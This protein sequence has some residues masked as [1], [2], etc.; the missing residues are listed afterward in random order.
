MKALL[1]LKKDSKKDF[2]EKKE[3]ALS[4]TRSNGGSAS[5]G[6]A[7]GGQAVSL[8][9][10]HSSINK[11]LD[12]QVAGKGGSVGGASF[13]GPMPGAAE[14][15]A[16]FE[17]VLKYRGIVGNDKRKKAMMTKPLEEKWKLVVLH[18]KAMEEQNVRLGVLLLWRHF[19][20]FYEKNPSCR[21]CS[22]SRALL[23]RS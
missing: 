20:S 9:L 7:S 6:A 21:I 13:G 18:E 8:T 19:F 17:K 11:E 1:G 10:L 14:V 4:R 23:H 16:R 12:G 22:H 5:S 15:N 2:K 3:K